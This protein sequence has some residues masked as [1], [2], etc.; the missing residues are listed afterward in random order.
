MGSGGTTCGRR[1]G[2]RGESPPV[3][4][5]AHLFQREPVSSPRRPER[6]GKSVPS[7]DRDLASVELWERS[8][9]RSVRRR[10]LAPAARRQRSRRTRASVAAT[11]PVAA[12]PYVPSVAAA[13]AAHG[14]EGGSPATS[15]S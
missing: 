15:A 13:S 8:L 3:R 12:A 11:A 6:K 14:G 9:E 7:I 2:R 5:V 4:G 1:I 10:E